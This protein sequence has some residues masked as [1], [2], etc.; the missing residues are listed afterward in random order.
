[1]QELHG[2]AHAQEQLQ[3][4]IKHLV[5]AGKASDVGTLLTMRR[6]GGELVL[7]HVLKEIIQIASRI[8]EPVPD[9]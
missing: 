3:K 8:S 4:A 2:T 5:P 6:D 7:F 1:M 9:L